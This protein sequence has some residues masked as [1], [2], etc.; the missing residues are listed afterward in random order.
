[1][2]GPRDPPHTC[3]MSGLPKEPCNPMETLWK[4]LERGQSQTEGPLPLPSCSCP[5]AEPTRAAPVL[6]AMQPCPRSEAPQHYSPGPWP[7]ALGVN[8]LVAL[9]VLSRTPLPPGRTQLHAATGYILYQRGE[10]GLS[11][12]VTGPQSSLPQHPPASHSSPNEPAHS[13]L[14]PRGLSSRPSWQ[15]CVLRALGEQQ[16]Y[17][18]SCHPQGLQPQYT[19]C[20]S[21]TFQENFC[22]DRGSRPQLSRSLDRADLRPYRSHQG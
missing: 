17:M 22:S 8:Q 18:A 11:L 9:T 15:G 16:P 20:P 4:L 21:G 13:H 6:S 3:P 14:P 7:A 5:W 10:E 19:E 2:E 12:G 1:M